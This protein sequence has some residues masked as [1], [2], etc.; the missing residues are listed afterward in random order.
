MI[1]VSEPGFLF[2]SPRHTVEMKR[3][4]DSETGFVRSV[5]VEDHSHDIDAGVDEGRFAGNAR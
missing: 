4:P 2:T 3:N 5:L 1:Q